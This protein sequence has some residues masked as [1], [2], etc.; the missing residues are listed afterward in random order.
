MTCCH[1]DYSEPTLTW[2]FSEL[3]LN[4]K[5]PT[6]W[7]GVNTESATGE[8]VIFSTYITKYITVVQYRVQHCVLLR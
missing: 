7:D 3:E 1:S 2:I 4:L 6:C 8:S 5:F